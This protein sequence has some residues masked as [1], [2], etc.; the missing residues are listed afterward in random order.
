VQETESD[1]KTLAFR[2]TCRVE[3]SEEVGKDGEREGDADDQIDRLKAAQIESDDEDR[4]GTRGYMGREELSQRSRGSRTEPKG[5]EE[6]RR[7]LRCT[8]DQRRRGR[9]KDDLIKAQVLKRLGISEPLFGVQ[10]VIR[11][12][13]VA[14]LK[15]SP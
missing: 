10:E 4:Q 12:I 1:S 7:P 5:V 14:F 6:G 8:I 11:I 15:R 9:K 3:D 2:T 13:S